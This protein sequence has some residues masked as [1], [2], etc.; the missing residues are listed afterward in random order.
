MVPVTVVDTI[1]KILTGNFNNAEY[2]GKAGQWFLNKHPK[3]VLADTLLK[4][5]PNNIAAKQIKETMEQGLNDIERTTSGIGIASVIATVLVFAPFS[6]GV[7]NGLKIIGLGA[8]APTFA[9]NMIKHFWHN[10]NN[11]E[12]SLDLGQSNAKSDARYMNYILEEQSAIIGLEEEYIG[13]IRYDDLRTLADYTYTDLDEMSV[14]QIQSY[15]KIIEE[16]DTEDIKAISDGPRR[17]IFEL[18]ERTKAGI[19]NDIKIKIGETVT[20]KDTEGLQQE[21]YLEMFKNKGYVDSE[22]RGVRKAISDVYD[23]MTSLPEYTGPEIRKQVYGGTY[24][25]YENFKDHKHLQKL[26]VLTREH[27]AKLSLFPKGDTA[28]DAEEALSRYT[29]FTRS[30]RGTKLKGLRDYKLIIES[31]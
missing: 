3:Y 11:P 2:V 10:L 23:Y 29:G 7:L 15:K 30:G 5:N 9:A 1:Q 16:I 18:A 25:K 27:P 20:S 19:L 4:Q 24:G 8:V 22:G 6:N 12:A 14:E 13:T 21:D 28:K 31:I 17:G 26:Y